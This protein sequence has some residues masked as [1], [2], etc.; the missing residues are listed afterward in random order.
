MK[1]LGFTLKGFTLT[2]QEIESIHESMNRPKIEF[3]AYIY[4]LLQISKIFVLF[5]LILYIPSTIFQLNRDGS[6]WVEP[7]LS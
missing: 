1:P 2:V 7:V 4:I 5:D 3:I 6:S